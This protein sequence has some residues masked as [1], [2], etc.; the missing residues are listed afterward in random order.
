MHA[1]TLVAVVIGLGLVLSSCGDDGS[2]DSGPVAEGSPL[3][4]LSDLNDLSALDEL[5][6]LGDLEQLE[7]TLT[8]FGGEGSGSV[9]INGA[10]IEF[11]SELCF[12]TGG[13]FSIEGPG[14]AST[15]EVAWVAIDYTVD[16]REELLEIFDEATLQQLYGDA[17]VIVDANLDIEY[18]RTE[19]LGSGAYDQPSFSASSVI[20]SEQVTAT[21]DGARI[22]GT[23]QATDYN[24]VAG[25]FDDAFDFTFSAACS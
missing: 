2:D 7:E 14:T 4:A 16:S 9:E 18:G 8:S 25:T 3:E 10:T 13:D 17:D 19:L 1:R 21:V 6:E 12:A 15:G 22:S 11:T 24:A 23:G 5:D 20:G